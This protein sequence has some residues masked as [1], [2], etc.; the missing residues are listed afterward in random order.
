MAEQGVLSDEID[1]IFK[2]EKE[3][4]ANRPRKDIKHVATAG[5]ET[6]KRVR[7]RQNAEAEA[8]ARGD[9][10]R[11]GPGTGNPDGTG[12]HGLEQGG[13]H[14]GIGR[15]GELR[16]GGDRAYFGGRLGPRGFPA[17]GPPGQP[18]HGMAAPGSMGTPGSMPYGV[19]GFPAWGPPR[20][21]F[22]GGPPGNV[23]AL[24]GIPYG[25]SGTLGPTP[26]Q[27]P[28]GLPPGHRHFPSQQYPPPRPAHQI[29][30]ANGFA[31]GRGPPHGGGVAVMQGA[32]FQPRF[33][34]PPPPPPPP[35]LPSPHFPPRQQIPNPSMFI[36]Q[37]QQ[38]QQQQP[39]HQARPL[40]FQQPFV[41]Y[42]AQPVNPVVLPPPP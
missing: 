16:G 39:Q 3:R 42:G 21:G 4:K 32:R 17:A 15:G 10:G 31:S 11:G 28:R 35:L 38:Q 13:P 40:R 33:A 27:Y 1:A 6:R 36:Q 34:R 20:N 5:E 8:R 41:G 25:M 37:Q 30:A 19:P 14:S 24:S 18:G 22:R 9:Q 12:T 26:Q 7:G 2:E 23:G 29:R